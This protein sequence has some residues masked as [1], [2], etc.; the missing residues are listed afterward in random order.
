MWTDAGAKEANLAPILLDTLTGSLGG[1]IGPNE[2]VQYLYGLGGTSAFSERFTDELALAAGPVHLPITKDRALFDEVA[3]LGKEL[4]AWHTWGERYADAPLSLGEAAEVT[5]ITGRP[6]GF[7]YDAKTQT[8]T[9]GTGKIAPVSPEVW[10]FEVSGFKPLQKWLGYRKAKRAGRTS[11]PLDAITYDEWTFTD[12]L[13]L[14][15]NILQHTVD[16]TPRAAALLARVLLSEI[17]TAEE[18]G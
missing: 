6:E 7:S 13:L 18:L 4:L 8:L 15:V 11:S 16:L 10:D 5:T 14:V 9:V 17:F 3:A 12:E 1:G 2:L